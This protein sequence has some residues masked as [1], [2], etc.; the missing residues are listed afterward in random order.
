MATHE[1]RATTDHDEIRRWAEARDGK[2]ATVKGTEKGEAA[3][4]LR[5]KFPTGGSDDRL[6]E[7]SWDDF[8]D[9]FDEED[10]SMIY[11]DET[12][13]HDT[14]RFFKFVTKE[15]AREATKK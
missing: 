4:L 6:D 9:K 12:K 14:S 2:P 10:L 7:I 1:T 11:Q 8:F 5:F 15:T 13:G 3:G